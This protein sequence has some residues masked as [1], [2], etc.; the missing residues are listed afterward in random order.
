MTASTTRNNPNSV[1]ISHSGFRLVGSSI[2]MSAPIVDGLN[3]WRRNSDTVAGAHQFRNFNVSR[4]GGN[5]T[6]YRVPQRAENAR[7]G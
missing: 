1:S 5:V 7:S 4:G 6:S 3:V 2:F